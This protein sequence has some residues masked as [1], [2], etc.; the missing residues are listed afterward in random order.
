MNVVKKCFHNLLRLVIILKVRSFIFFWFN[1]LF[2]KILRRV[3]KLGSFQVI[4]SHMLLPDP[5][6]IKSD[7][8]ILD[9]TVMSWLPSTIRTMTPT[10]R[11]KPNGILLFIT[12]A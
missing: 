1:F 7:A 12:N 4:I 9:A 3:S 8:D 6:S 11:Y 5:K 10:I 2:K